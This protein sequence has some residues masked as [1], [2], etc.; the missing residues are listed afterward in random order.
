MVIWKFGELI[1]ICL[2]LGKLK[3]G[4]MHTPFDIWFDFKK[5]GVVGLFT[6]FIGTCCLKGKWVIGKL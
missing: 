3:L 6:L 1:I 5:V 2:D 4:R